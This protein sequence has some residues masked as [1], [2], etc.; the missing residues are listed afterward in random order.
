MDD[1]YARTLIDRAT[2]IAIYRR[3]NPCNVALADNCPSAAEALFNYLNERPGRAYCNGASEGFTE[4]PSVHYHRATLP[5]IVERVRRGPPGN[6]VVVHGI[7]PPGT[8]LNGRAMT[9][10]HYFILVRLG[11]PEDDVFWADCSHP[12]DGM[13]FP[14]R[15]RD[16]FNDTVESMADYNKL[17]SF[18]FTSGPFAVRPVQIH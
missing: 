7:R 12:E 5:S 2:R 1:K 8:I 10:D 6:L 16:G 14:S 15:R 9:R 4:A 11:P 18:E 13:F 3:L 17:R